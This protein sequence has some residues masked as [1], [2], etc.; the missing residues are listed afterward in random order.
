[1]GNI[2]KFNEINENE[3]HDD[4]TDIRVKDIIEFLQTFDPET[5]V[6]LDK[7]GWQAYGDESKADV[8]R[9]LFDDSGITHRGRDYIMVNN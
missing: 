9:G 4:I 6:Y 2:K 5:K 1:M 8:I 7:D 3:S